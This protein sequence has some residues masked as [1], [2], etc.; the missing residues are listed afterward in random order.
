MSKLYYRYNS[1]YTFLKQENNSWLWYI[2]FKLKI[3]ENKLSYN[4]E[5]LLLKFEYSK[6]IEITLCF[7]CYVG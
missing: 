4:Y 3:D 2:T 1:L 6:N 5:I 7:K